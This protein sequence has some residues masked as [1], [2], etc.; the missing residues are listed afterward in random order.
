VRLHHTIGLGLIADTFPP[1]SSYAVQHRTCD[2]Y[3]DADPHSNTSTTHANET[4]L[5]PTTAAT[6]GTSTSPA[7][8]APGTQT[9]CGPELRS[10]KP[11]DMADGQ[12]GLVLFTSPHRL[13]INTSTTHAS[14]QAATAAHARGTSGANCTTA[15]TCAHRHDILPLRLQCRFLQLG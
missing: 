8:T 14:V 12:E 13:S 7:A 9:A 10:G 11:P 3:N 15:A 1:L 5:R 6:T 4:A 2:D